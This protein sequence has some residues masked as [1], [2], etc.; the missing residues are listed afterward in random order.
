MTIGDGKE[1]RHWGH[2]QMDT[3]WQRDSQQAEDASDQHGTVWSV[4]FTFIT[5]IKIAAID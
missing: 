5:V 3:K 2:V 1:G 4:T